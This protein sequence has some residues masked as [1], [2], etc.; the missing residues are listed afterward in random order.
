MASPGTQSDN[1]DLQY[2]DNMD[3]LN[4]E[5]RRK[6]LAENAATFEDT[7]LDMLRD[8]KD[9]LSSMESRVASLEDQQL[10]HAEQLQD[11]VPQ[12]QSASLS[13]QP[14]MLCLLEVKGPHSTLSLHL[15]HQAPLTLL[16]IPHLHCKAALPL[17]S[18][19]RALASGGSI[20]GLC[21]R[22]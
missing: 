11:M 9:G 16:Q 10:P 4:E 14:Q 20:Y 13:T 18:L 6:E 3:L 7:V 17:H 21:S 5:V 19:A 2:Q 12:G 8:L 22:S 1:K 15:R